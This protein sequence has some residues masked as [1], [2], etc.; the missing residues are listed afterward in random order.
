MRLEEHGREP[1]NRGVLHW[2]TVALVALAWILGTFGDELSE[3][4]SREAGLFAHI[5]M[6]LVILVVAVVRIP[7]RSAN[8][9][10][11]VIPTE[12]GRW[13]VEWTDP[14]SRIM[15]YVLYALLLAVPIL[16]IV[17]QF[18]RGQSLPF[19]GL[20]EIP[21]PWL[22]DKVFARSLKE[23]HE[24]SANVLVILALF[25]MSAAL[26]HHLVFGDSALRRMLPHFRVKG[27]VR[28][29]A[30]NGTLVCQ[31]AR[32]L[33]YPECGIPSECESFSRPKSISSASHL[34]FWW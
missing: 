23:V 6:G 2:V 30:A 22:A 9:P 13:L 10:P 33:N 21:S 34:H 11:K 26:L 25:H 15:Q 4:P 5:S 12:F 28:D 27:C 17:L 16:A 29:H 24:V 8:P 7:W 18:A 19:F 31:A 1:D 20:F 3:G 14:V 32:A